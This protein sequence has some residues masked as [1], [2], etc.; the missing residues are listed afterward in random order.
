MVWCSPLWLSVVQTVFMP[1]TLL[2]VDI[3]SLQC[4][5]L[6][7]PWLLLSWYLLKLILKSLV[8]SSVTPSVSVFPSHFFNFFLSLSIFSTEH[9]I[10]RISL[11]TSTTILH[12]L[13]I[14]TSVWWNLSFVGLLH[15]SASLIPFLTLAPL[16][17]T[18]LYPW[19]LISI[20]HFIYLSS[21]LFPFWGLWILP[22]HCFWVEFP[23]YQTTSHLAPGN[24][25]AVWRTSTLTTS[26]WT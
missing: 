2:F 14:L 9:Y 18:S 6:H 20:L 17:F 10:H 12:F 25:L 21:S 5:L 3:F 1:L 8:C 13:F 7:P 24:L 22:V 23:M 19:D 16:L 26:W 11:Q 15:P 4:C